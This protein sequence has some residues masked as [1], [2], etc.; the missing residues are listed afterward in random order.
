M[1]HVGRLALLC[2]LLDPV[3][4]QHDVQ[5]DAVTVP[6]ETNV[7]EHPVE[8]RKRN[9]NVSNIAAHQSS[10]AQSQSRTK[11]N[12]SLDQGVK[13]TK[14]ASHLSQV[15][16]DLHN[17]SRN[18][19]E[20]GAT[21][22]TSNSMNNTSNSTM[23]KPSSIF[24]G[25]S[26]NCTSLSK[27]CGDI[28]TLI[29]LSW[30]FVTQ[31]WAAAAA[32]MFTV[33]ATVLSI[34]QIFA[35]FRK[36]RHREIRNYTVRILFMVP[37]FALESFLALCFIE[38]APVMRM[39][40]E[41]YEAFALFSFTSFVL[42][43]LGGAGDLAHMLVDDKPVHHVFPLCYVKPWPK[44][45]KFLR[46]TLLG[47]L[48]YIPVAICITTIGLICWYHDLYGDGTID[49]TKAYIYCVSI[50][51]LSQMWAL[52]CLILLYR[53]TKTRLQ[54]INPLRKFL[55]IKLIIFFT[56]WQGLLLTALISVREISEADRE[57]QKHWNSHSPRINDPIGEGLTNLIICIEMVFFALAHR[58]AYPS[59]EF[60]DEKWREIRAGY[61][62]EEESHIGH[63]MEGINMLDFLYSFEE[64][65][66]IDTDRHD[67][68]NEN[69][70][71]HRRV[72]CWS[73]DTEENSKLL[74][75]TG[76]GPAYGAVAVFGEEAGSHQSERGGARVVKY[77][78][79]SYQQN[80]YNERT[81]EGCIV[82]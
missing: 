8:E 68:K 60:S 69:V 37:V 16:H 81:G 76:V 80:M 72:N 47:V 70:Q 57:I 21:N 78:P 2:I 41:F 77:H 9:L 40:R 31:R 20:N 82:S 62:D 66:D 25:H 19:N 49:F 39:L 33:L 73:G 67:T 53:A 17:A 35:H 38:T 64:F 55:C 13:H 44:G 43:Y 59:N 23:F 6:S 24:S 28:S 58:Y 52:Y 3:Q 75:Q 18:W 29:D 11:S 32:F 30:W 61:D 42:T 45:G 1:I 14:A 74:K 4:S 22:K 54:P 7:T 79:N 26:G 36:N 5:V 48:Q 71:E 56:W 15:H 63:I 10:R 27:D 51:N 65:N 12:K 34:S 50:Q 46:A